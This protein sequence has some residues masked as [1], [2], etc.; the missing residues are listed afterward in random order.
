M[1]GRNPGAA[2][3][4]R[5]ILVATMAWALAG[6]GVEPRAG[7]RVVSPRTLKELEAGSGS[8]E[9]LSLRRTARGFAARGSWSAPSSVEVPMRLDSGLP[10]IRAQLNGREVEL[11][12]DTG[13]QAT[14]LEADTALHCGVRTAKKSEGT[15]SLSGISGSESALMGVPERIEIGRWSWQGMP[16][17]VRTTQSEIPRQGFLGGGRRFLINVLGMDA[18]RRMCSFVTLDYPGAKAVFGFRD[19]F[20]PVAGRKSW[21]TPMVEKGGLPHVRVGDGRSK[22][23]AVVDTGSSSCVE[24]GRDIA[25][26]GGLRRETDWPRIFRMGVGTTNSTAA[27]PVAGIR[28]LELLGPRLLNVPAVLV[29]DSAKIGSGLLRQFRVTLDFRRS[30]LWLE[31]PR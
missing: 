20:K 25:E 9:E 29:P 7:T 18:M 26:R 15:L 30:A 4:A 13:S 22:W 23:M 28:S 16:C 19:A 17:L 6:C 1:A 31:S 3:K 10:H 12:V 5:W 14:V 21:R 11:I 2:G 8:L 24:V 27:V